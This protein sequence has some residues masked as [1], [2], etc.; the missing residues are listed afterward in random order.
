MI[1]SDIT[2]QPKPMSS[3][4]TKS[5]NYISAAYT[6]ITAREGGG[7]LYIG[8]INFNRAHSFRNINLSYGAFGFGGVTDKRLQNKSF[9]GGGL[10]STLGYHLSSASGAVDFR[11]ISWENA[12]SFESGNYANF[13]ESLNANNEPK[14]YGVI[15]SKET[16]LYTTGGSTEIIWHP[17][18][19]KN[20]QFSFRF[21]YGFS[22]GITKTIENTENIYHKRGSA[23]DFSFYYKLNKFYGVFNVG[24]NRNTSAKFT[25]GY[26]F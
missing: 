13:R 23:I 6:D 22:P 21:F 1:G 18:S 16:T 8:N 26:A 17:K 10:R 15:Y 19:N 4:S 24:G 9:F 25:L 3:D 7:K 5:K 2:Y 20:N 14:Y 12:L 11:L